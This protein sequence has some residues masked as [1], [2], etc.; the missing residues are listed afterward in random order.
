MLRTFGW[1]GGRLQ[2]IP[3]PFDETALPKVGWI[4]AI[5]PTPEESGLVE[6][7]AGLKVSNRDELAEIESSSRLAFEDGILYL[8]M[9][10]L[11]KPEDGPARSAPLG[12]V[13]AKDRLVT[14]R[15]EAS[16]LFDS[17]PDRMR[18]DKA[19]GA[20]PAH[21]FVSLLEA[22]VDRLADLLEHIRADLDAISSRAFGEDHARYKP[23]RE[24]AELRA[25]LKRIGRIGDLTS[26]I[27]D[28]LLGIARIV[29]YAAQAGADFLPADLRPRLK[30][31]RQDISSL[32]DYDAY[33][34][35]KIQFLLDAV[36]GFI[37]IA[38]NNIIKVLTVVSVVGV[39][40]TL[41]ASIYGM[42][43][44]LMPELEWA[45][46]YPYALTLILISAIGPLLWFKKRGWF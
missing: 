21:V 8:S 32:A 19:P 13:L 17:F 33:L 36:L 3:L 1:V 15:F 41:V 14:I 25:T 23:K 11:V 38:Q 6:R 35:N 20:S 40:P 10:Q 2:P 16:R 34:A 27:R 7:L 44:K 30:T 29:P 37:S 18:L 4:D 9:S 31:L 43:F 39:P 12:F 46:G 22:I 45:F 24:D 5:N 28:S 42:N 26:R